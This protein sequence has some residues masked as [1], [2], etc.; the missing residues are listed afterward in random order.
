MAAYTPRIIHI[1]SI[2]LAEITPTLS[3]YHFLLNNRILTA[4]ENQY[5]E[6]PWALLAFRIDQGEYFREHSYE[7]N[8]LQER[9][10]DENFDQRYVTLERLKIYSTR[11]I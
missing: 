4:G 1:P 5:P 2:N 3:S 7:E 11:Q 9:V 6:D 10:D 8:F